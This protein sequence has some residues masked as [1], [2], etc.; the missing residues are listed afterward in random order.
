ME[1]HVTNLKISKSL[2]KWG[3]IKKTEY[4]WV[5]VYRDK[6]TLML[7]SEINQFKN[8]HLQDFSA[9]LA[10]ELGDLLPFRVKIPTV[11]ETKSW[12]DWELTIHNANNKWTVAYAYDDKEHVVVNE[13]QEAETMPDAMG[14]MLIY[15]LENR[16]FEGEGGGK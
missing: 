7:T 4:S 11:F 15:L 5:E 1:K 12:M 14:K 3:I 16:L 9:L 2:S 10:S 13:S 6:W 8:R